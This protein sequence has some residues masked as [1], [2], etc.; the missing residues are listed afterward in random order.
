MKTDDSSCVS[1]NMR[2]WFRGIKVKV[3]PTAADSHDC[4]EADLAGEV[5]VEIAL[6][7][8]DHHRI[9]LSV[10]PWVVVDTTTREPGRPRWKII[11]ESCET[12]HTFI[13]NF[14]HFWAKPGMQYAPLDFVKCQ[15]FKKTNSISLDNKGEKKAKNLRY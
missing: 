12:G 15:C 14:S 7:L 8:V 6:K 5:S 3:I 9:E 2:I 4:L 10:E 13:T 11:T 1:F